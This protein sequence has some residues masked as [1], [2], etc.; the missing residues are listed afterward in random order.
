MLNF[1]ILLLIL[2]AFVY[3]PLLAVIKKRQA[4]IKEGLEKAEEATV[5]LQEIDV[6]AKDKL[7]QADQE[8]IS[9]IKETEQR[10]R[11]L[12]QILQSKAEERGIYGKLCSDCE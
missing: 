5:R 11:V 2:R 10:A 7:K 8:S 3:K 6:I 4:T 12:E 9:I 1:F